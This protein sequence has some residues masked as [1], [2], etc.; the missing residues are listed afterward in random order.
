[1]DYNLNQNYEFRRHIGSKT[2]YYNRD[3]IEVLNK[4]AFWDKTLRDLSEE[5]PNKIDG[6]LEKTVLQYCDWCN[7][8]C[9]SCSGCGGGGG[10]CSG[11]SSC[12]GCE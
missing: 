12:G 11:C 1:M 7:S 2:T 5:K 3:E 9:S 4:Y 8:G 10:G 6:D